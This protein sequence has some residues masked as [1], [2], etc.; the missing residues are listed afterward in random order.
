VE[1]YD[2][3]VCLFVCLFGW[4]SPEPHGQSSPNFLCM[5]HVTLAQSFSGD[6]AIRYVLP[7]YWMMSCLPIMGHMVYFNTGA[8]SDVYD[9]LVV[10]TC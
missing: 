2:Q 1:Y 9:C 4:I 6:V 7:D 10:K 8:E 3:S 5:L